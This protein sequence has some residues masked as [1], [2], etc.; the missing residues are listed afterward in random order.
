MK[1]IFVDLGAYNGDSIE[2][3]MKLK[4]LPVSPKDFDIYAFEPNPEY[5]KKV[6]A[7][8]DKYTNIK[9]V[10]NTCAWVKEGKETFALDITDNPMGST[11]MSSKTE[12]WNNS[13]H[14]EVDTFDFTDWIKQFKSDYIIV[15]MDIEGAE[16]VILQKMVDMGIDIY[17]DE[18]WVEMHPN[19]VED[20]TITNAIDLKNS[21]RCD[22]K[23]WT[24]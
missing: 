13:P 15:K 20:Y 17:M 23:D 12:L 14:I 10:N 7:L 24:F 6:E 3:F 9:E 8:K 18:L 19:K 1:F 16:F 2:Y 5:C 11:L 21:L 4:N 22:V